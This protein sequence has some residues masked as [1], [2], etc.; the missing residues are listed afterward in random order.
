MNY[1]PVALSEAASDDIERLFDYILYISGSA[2]TAKNYTD[3]ILEFCETI[4]WV[5]E[6]GYRITWSGRRFRRRIFEKSIYILYERKKAAITI[7]RVISARRD[8]KELR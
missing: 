6:G 4:G 3:R 8:E 5:P 7:I 2:I 1:T